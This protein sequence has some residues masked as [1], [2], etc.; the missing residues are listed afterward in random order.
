[1]QAY[2]GDIIIAV[3]M[4]LGI[5]FGW[6]R[7]LVKIIGGC[8]AVYFGIVAGRHITAAIMPWVDGLIKGAAN[9][10]GVQTYEEEI[11]TTLLFSN[12]LTARIIEVVVLVFVTIIVVAILRR[13]ARFLGNVINHTPLIGFISRFFGAILAFLVFTAAMYAVLIWVFPLLADVEFVARLNSIVRSSQYL[14]P[15][16]WSLGG[17]AW[18]VAAAGIALWQAQ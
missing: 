18:S 7:G 5:L 14:L 17:W 6:K 4:L 9:S 1:M 16:V 8:G 13:L 10:A 2:L 3:V 12:T 11:L 15:Y